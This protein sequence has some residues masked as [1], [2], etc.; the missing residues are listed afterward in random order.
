VFAIL[1]LLIFT[2]LGVGLAVAVL[3]EATLVRGVLLRAAMKLL[4]DWNYLPTW[5]QWPPH[6]GPG[7][8][9]VLPPDTAKAQP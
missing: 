3:I 7:D 9:K 8:G 2:Q 5:L 4:G 1:S 6:V